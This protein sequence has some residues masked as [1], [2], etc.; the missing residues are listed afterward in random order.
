MKITLKRVIGN[1]FRLNIP[2]EIREAVNLKI[3]DVVTFDI[4][5]SGSII[6]KKIEE[7]QNEKE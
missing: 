6:V 7:K 2:P 3:G 4:T 1:K 5:K